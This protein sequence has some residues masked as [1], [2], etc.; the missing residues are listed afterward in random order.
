[1]FHNRLTGRRYPLA[2]LAAV[3]LAL[4]ACGGST[5]PTPAAPGTTTAPIGAPTVT[6][7]ALV[8]APT[9]AVATAAPTPAA[10][11]TPAQDPAASA[12]Q[13]IFDAAD[14]IDTHGPYKMRIT[15]TQ[16]DTPVADVFVVPPDKLRIVFKNSDGTP[17]ETVQIG[18]TSYNLLDGKWRVDT[19]EPS[20]GGGNPAL[21]DVPKLQDIQNIQPLGAK[22]VNGVYA[23][24]FTF[25]DAARPGETNTIWIGPDGAPVQMIVVKPEETGTFDIVY[26]DSI[27]I[28]APVK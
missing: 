18:N 25:A 17:F 4:A 27:T 6:V 3:A 15:S 22:E 11:A 13:L 8:V 9:N 10:S 1:M 2:V 19:I 16:A 7:T 14:K 23:S 12:Q 28:D 21:S 26:D 24:G 20:E 5:T